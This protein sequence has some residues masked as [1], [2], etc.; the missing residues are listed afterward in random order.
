MESLENADARE[1]RRANPAKVPTRDR[2]G[3]ID[4]TSAAWRNINHTRV[5]ELGYKQTGPTLPLDGSISEED[6]FRDLWPVWQR[7][8]GEQLRDEAKRQV[9]EWWDFGFEAISN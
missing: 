1:Q 7:I 4:I 6:V 5:A 2:Q 8:H 3:I 9:R